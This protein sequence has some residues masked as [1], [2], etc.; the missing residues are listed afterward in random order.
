MNTEVIGIVFA[1]IGLAS[2]VLYYVFKHRE[3]KA[4][5]DIRDRLKEK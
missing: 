5:E 4:L 1:V 2:T 3:V